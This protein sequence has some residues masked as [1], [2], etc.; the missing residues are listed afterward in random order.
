[1]QVFI[2]HQLQP[3]LFTNETLPFGAQWI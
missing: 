3:I 2:F 1:M